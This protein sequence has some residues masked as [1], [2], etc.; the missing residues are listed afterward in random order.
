[1]FD[2]IA[3]LIPI[4][5]FVCLFAIVRAVIDGRVKRRLAET[6]AS[7]AMVRALFEADADR[8]RQETLKWGLLLGAIGLSLVVTDLLGL[9]GDD[10]GAYG[11]LLGA[12]GLAL[13]VHRGLQGRDG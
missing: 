2:I 4:V 10:P 7:E 9:G 6:Q 5:G 12:A 13:L 3:L 1:M 11:L 8:R